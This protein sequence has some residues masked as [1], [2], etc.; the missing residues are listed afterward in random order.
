MEKLRNSKDSY[1]K[2]K[3]NDRKSESAPEFPPFYHDFDKVLLDIAV[4]KLPAVK[5]IGCK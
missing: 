4:V 3:E 1:K 5:Q 2:A